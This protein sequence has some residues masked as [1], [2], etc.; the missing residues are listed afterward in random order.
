VFTRRWIMGKDRI[1]LNAGLK[2]T[3]RTRLIRKELTTQFKVQKAEV[4]TVVDLVNYWN[5]VS[6]TISSRE[7]TKHLSGS[8]LLSFWV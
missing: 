4:L 5:R 8:V 1:K 3:S 2:T 6:D 7:D